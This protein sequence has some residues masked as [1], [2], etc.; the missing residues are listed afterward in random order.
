MKP[1]ASS[2]TFADVRFD[3]IGVPLDSEVESR[4]ITVWNRIE[5][6]GR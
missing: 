1:F 6:G 4:L 3:L 2:S 5:E